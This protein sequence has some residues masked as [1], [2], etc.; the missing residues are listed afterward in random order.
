MRNRR[1]HWFLL[2]LVLAGIFRLALPLGAYLPP[3]MGRRLA[4]IL[5]HICA[6][7][8]LDWRTSALR[9][10]YVSA[11][12]AEALAEITP[13]SDDRTLSRYLG[14]RFVNASLE[15]LEGH[16]LA[17]GR[18]GDF[19]CGFEGLHEVRAALG[20]GQGMVLLTFHFDAALMGV[21][22]MGLEGI[23][24]NLMTSDVV[25][26]PRVMPAVQ[27]YFTN[28][29]SGIA[30]CL[31]GG[32]VLHVENHLKDFYRA[33]RAGQGVVVL[34]DAPVALKDGALIVSFFEKLRVFAPG[35]VRMAEK[36]KAPITAFVCLRQ[37]DGPYRTIFS[38]VYWPENGSHADNVPLLYSFLESWVRRHPDRWWVA[39]QLPN[40]VCLDK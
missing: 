12:T 36:L 11:R 38:P 19:R 16:W 2:E 7:L 22:Q 20:Q 30:N 34:G 28:K 26:D 8:D 13:L 24:L 1:L 5:G 6:R 25:E 27:K 39:D 21:A 4:E 35:A 17:N 29:Y 37:D 33:L 14:Q 40:F 3:A 32:G 18:A 9:K 10:H 15:E 23:T 31:N